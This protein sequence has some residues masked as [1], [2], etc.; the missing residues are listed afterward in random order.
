MDEREKKLNL[1]AVALVAPPGVY[2]RRCKVEYN[3]G[4]LGLV[5]RE[6]PLP[7]RGRYPM[8]LGW[9]HVTSD[10]AKPRLFVICYVVLSTLR[11]W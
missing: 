10:H 11:V 8:T 9:E 4:A 5:P 6:T 3:N 2:G 1:C 7:N